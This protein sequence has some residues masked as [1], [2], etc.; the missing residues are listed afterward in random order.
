[1]LDQQETLLIVD[2]EPGIRNLLHQKL[3]R[4]GYQCQ[5]AETAEQALNK[6]AISPIALVILDIKMPG[7]SGIELLPEIKSACPDTAVIMAT[8]IIDIN[9]AVECLKQGADDYIC[10]PFN[11]EEVSL[12]VQRALEKRRLQLE[13]RDYQQ[14]LEE[15]VE[16][17]TGEIKK[18][19]LGAIEA[20]VFALEAKDK[21]TGGHSRRV[22]EIALALGNE[23][24]L[25]AR[26]MEDLR[27][28]SLLHDVG[29][30]A[31]DQA[32]QNKPSKLT[33]EEYEHIMT[34]AGV[35]AH[36]VKPL[37]NGKISEMI[38]HHHDHYDGSGLHQVIAGSDIPL[39]ARIIAVADAFDAMISDRPYRSA[40]SVTEAIDEIKSGAGTQFDLVVVN[41]F[42]KTA[43][44]AATRARSL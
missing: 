1:M 18:L 34:H 26:D 10:K 42:L 33:R 17:Q 7:K 12:A 13:V 14:F 36:I 30:I 41:A 43:G 39:G 40:M 31:I 23:L 11:L 15:K 27:W 22:T 4:E 8:A 37:V 5:E 9:V 21:Y 35:G 44:R 3:S 38:E 28:G 20:L 2:D 25:S 16:E 19:F 32:I 6:L 29:K 24:G